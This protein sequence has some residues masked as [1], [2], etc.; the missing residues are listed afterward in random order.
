VTPNIADV[1]DA[2]VVR[3]WAKVD[4]DD[5]CWLWTASV[6]NHGYGQFG[7]AGGVVLAHRLAYVLT[8]GPIPSGLTIDHLCRVTTCVRPAHLEPV[9]RAENNRRAAATRRY[10][11]RGHEYTDANTIRNGRG[12]R[13]CRTCHNEARRNV[14]KS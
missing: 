6:G 5:E 10:C 9:T 2:E 1:T 3:F 4:R 13:Y 8:V 11:P 7:A 14:E 12:W